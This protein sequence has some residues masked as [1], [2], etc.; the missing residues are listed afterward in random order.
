MARA[1]ETSPQTYA[2]VGGVL[3]LYIIIAGIL[4]ES[5]RDSL[6]VSG[7]P[8]ATAQ[9]VAASESL[10][11]VSV[12]GELLWLVCSV[13]VAL[14]LYVLLAP[15]HQHLVLLATF[16]NL[17][18]IAVL[19]VTT[20]SLVAVVFLSG[21]ASYLKAF[22]P[23]QLEALGYLS[24]KLSDY[25][26]AVCLVFFGCCLFL[27]GY[28][29]FRSSFF[30]KFLG[31]FLIIGSICYLINSFAYIL[32]PAFARII[33]PIILIPAGLSELALCLWLIV[34]GVNVPKW[35]EAASSSRS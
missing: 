26:Y 2:R 25:G 33:F 11:R 23:H 18:S 28:L 17:V 35:N 9:H 21:G 10:W 8:A 15:V 31:V 27:Y 7:D 12:A 34:V 32:A 6:V 5:F 19:A 30:P 1:V 16:F 20:V 24:L 4:A 22:E 29:I 14:I 3:Y 13:V